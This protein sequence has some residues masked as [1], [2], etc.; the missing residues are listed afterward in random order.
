MRT[1]LETY[2]TP[3]ITAIIIMVSPLKLFAAETITSSGQANITSTINKDI[4]RSRAIEN[5]ARER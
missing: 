3:L 4:Y 5:A 2:F 1:L